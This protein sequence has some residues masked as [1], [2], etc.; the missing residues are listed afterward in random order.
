[1][2]RPRL[3]VRKIKEI[4][5]LKFE[6]RLSERAIATACKVSRSTVADYLGR[7]SEAGFSWPLPADLSD[8]ELEARLFPTPPKPTKPGRPVPAWKEV[9]LELRRKGV[10]LWLLWEEYIEQYPN[11]YS[12]SRFCELYADWKKPLNAT[13]RQVHPAGEKLFVDWSGLTMPVV[14]ADTGEEYEAQIFVAVLG[15]SNYTYVEAT[16]SQSLP[17]WIGAHTRAFHFLGGVPRVVVPDNVR[18]GVTKANFY[19]PELNRTYA[20]MARHYGVA[21]LPTR[22]KAPRDKAKVEKGVQDI[23]RRILA[24]L[25][26]RRFFSLEEL[27]EAIDARLEPFNERRLQR[28][29]ETRRSL[30]EKLDRPKLR[31]LPSQSYTYAEWVKASAGLDYHIRV[32]DHF[33]SVPY[34]LS[35][36]EL[37]VRVTAT[38][39]ECFYKQERVA[40]HPRGYVKNGY[41]T[42][43]EHMPE[44]HRK[45]AE[46]NPE[47][48]IRWAGKTGPA[49]AEVTRRIMAERE[50]PEQGFR[51]CMGI[52]RLSKNYGPDRTEAACRRALLAG[53]VRYRSVASILKKGLDQLELPDYGPESGP[54]NHTNIRGP[55]YY[56]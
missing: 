29:E 37:L 14:D 30:F 6:C 1:M 4:L 33:Y 46:W 41:A 26:H 5:R 48:L 36:R 39:I 21:V 25:R 42:V 20:E 27:N 13:M 54:I 31:P 32:D 52:M 35:H 50:Y 51:A 9:H 56:N 3:S 7:A 24:P 44:G 45:Y 55:Q 8:A 18:T 16:R 40:A 43:K 49:T 11:G 19:E 38:T 15:A 23:Q 12:Y 28:L 2:A 17:D 47:R 10:T 22:T 53:A 34:T